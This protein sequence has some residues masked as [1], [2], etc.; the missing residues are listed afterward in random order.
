VLKGKTVVRAVSVMGFLVVAIVAVGLG[1]KSADTDVQVED[2][3][4]VA[5][6]VEP[7]PN[8]AVSIPA[9]Q[10]SLD[11]AL[12]ATEPTAKTRGLSTQTT[13]NV[14]NKC[15]V[16]TGSVCY[17]RAKIVGSSCNCPGVLDAGVIIK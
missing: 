10:V 8:G 11:A 17:V 9:R 4:P 2:T 6:S 5:T 14:S 12:K 7:A 1:L 3:M 15:R 16:P 13:Q